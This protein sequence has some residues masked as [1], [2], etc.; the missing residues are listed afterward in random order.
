M[1][2]KIKFCRARPLKNRS[3]TALSGPDASDDEETKANVETDKVEIQTESQAPKHARPSPE[4]SKSKGSRDG[5]ANEENGEN[6]KETI[7]TRELQG[8]GKDVIQGGGRQLSR[9]KAQH[10]AISRNNLHNPA[11]FQTQ[12]EPNS[13]QKAVVPSPKK[14]RHWQT[15]TVNAIIKTT[16]DIASRMRDVPGDLATARPPK[17]DDLTSSAYALVSRHDK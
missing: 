13:T 8:H 11:F 12:R 5:K 3:T 6:G 15:T 7:G 1:A 4:Q 2:G 14:R 17:A 9:K 10:V 16:L